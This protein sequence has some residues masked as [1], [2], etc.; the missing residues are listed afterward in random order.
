MFQLLLIWM[1]YSKIKQHLI[2]DISNWDVSNVTTM[3]NMFDGA[4]SFDQ[5]IGGWNISSVNATWFMFR[6]ATSF[7]QPLNNWDMSS[8]QGMLF[9]FENADSFQQPLN[10]WEMNALQGTFSQ[11]FMGTTGDA[12]AITYTGYDA[13][14]I[15]WGSKCFYK[16]R[17]RQLAL[18]IQHLPQQ[19]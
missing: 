16:N 18:E 2:V 6:G 10:L 17:D 14:L 15:G 4:T 5:P 19:H 12:G 13:L 8:V 9:M 7:N 11:G 1:N 3:R